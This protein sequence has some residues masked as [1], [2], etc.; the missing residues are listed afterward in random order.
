M[1]RSQGLDVSH[2]QAG[3]DYSRIADAG[4]VRFIIIKATEGTAYVDPQFEW[5]VS[6]CVKY[7]FV[8][9]AYHFFHPGLDYTAQAKH[10]VDVVGKD[11]V[12]KFGD[13]EET[14][15]RPPGDVRVASL[16]WLKTMDDMVGYHTPVYSRAGWWNPIFS[17][18]EIE[19]FGRMSWPASWI[20]WPYVWP[21]SPTMLNGMDEWIVWQYAVYSDYGTKLDHDRFNGDDNA[22]MDWFGDQGAPPPPPVITYPALPIGTVIS[23]RGL[24]VRSGPSTSYKIVNVLTFDQNVEVIREV[25]VG[26]DIWVQLGYN[27][28][29]AYRYGGSTY[30][31]IAPPG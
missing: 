10:F 30:L 3:L 19:L 15:N 1:S 21:T 13:F 26:N 5:H 28:Y 4:L 20:N 2:W 14:D 9:A 24:N 29:A 12:R 6:Q 31:N 11:H 27:E 25:P 7:G 23:P 8:W 17:K 18:T 16:N 22:A